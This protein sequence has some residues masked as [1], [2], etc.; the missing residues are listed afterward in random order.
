MTVVKEFL[1]GGH[2]ATFFFIFLYI[3]HPKFD[4]IVSGFCGDLNGFLKSWFLPED[5]TG[6]EA[7]FKTTF[8]FLLFL[9][10]TQLRQEAC[11]GGKPECCEGFSPVHEGLI[12]TFE[13][14]K[15]NV[16]EIHR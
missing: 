6:V 9:R 8:W 14:T 12:L 7:E 13:M 2:R 10:K 16:W 15:A 5:C 1:Q 11:S 4:T 3:H